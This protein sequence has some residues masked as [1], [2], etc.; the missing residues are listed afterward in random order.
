MQTRQV[1]QIGWKAA[2][3]TGVVAAGAAA[4]VDAGMQILEQGGNAADAAVAT[5]LALNVTDHGLC[6]IGGEVPVLIYDTKRHEVKSL[7]GQGGAPLA[8]EAI[9]GT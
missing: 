7:S 5:I 3:P 8:P 9:A 2:S 4:A 1:E 6:S